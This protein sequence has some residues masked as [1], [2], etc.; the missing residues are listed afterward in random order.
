MSDVSE[1]AI[2]FEA[3]KTSMSQSKAG[4]ILR[5]AIHPNDVP[6]SL[7]TDW[8]GSRYM[9][10]MVK[11]DDEDQPEISD[12]QRQA[13]ALVA[14]AGMLC[15]NEDFRKY[16]DSQDLLTF[17]VGNWDDL[18]EEKMTA[19][20]LRRYLQIQSRSELATNSEAREKFKKLQEDFTLWKKNRP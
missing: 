3:V 7:H 6:P 5:I 2:H 20:C 13:K 9:V 19:N 16:L 8:V 18:S 1:A 11:L 12:D 10:A 14:S 15:R 17:E 4:T